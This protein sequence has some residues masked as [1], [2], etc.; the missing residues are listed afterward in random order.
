MVTADN[1]QFKK[2]MKDT[3]TETKRTG[4]SITDMG[5]VAKAALTGAVVV[6]L[7]RMGKALLNVAKQMDLMS[8][9][10]TAVFGQYKKE[11][12]DMAEDTASSMGL[13]KTEFV[14]TAAGIQ[15]LL[16]PIGFARKEATGMT[17]DMMSLAGALSTW[18]GGTVSATEVGNI[19]AKAMLGEREQLKTLGIA[20]SEAEIQSELLARGQKKLTGEALAQAKAQITLDL[21]TSKSTDAQKAFGEAQDSLV[22]N[23]AIV[24]ANVRSIGE[25]IAIIMDPAMRS[26]AQAAK[27]LTGQLKLLTDAAAEITGTDVGFFDKLRF[28]LAKAT[29]GFAGMV[30]QQGILNRHNAVTRDQ[31]VATTDAIFE[32]GGTLDD[33]AAAFE[34]Y[35]TKT[36]GTAKSIFLKREALARK[37]AAEEAAIEAERLAKIKESYD[38]QSA[39]YKKMFAEMAEA[40][41]VFNNAIRFTTSAAE[42]AELQTTKMTKVNHEA[43]VVLDQMPAT[44]AMAAQAL[45]ILGIQYDATATLASNLK[46]AFTESKIA[47]A[48]YASSISG[49]GTVL[50]NVLAGQEASMKSFFTATLQGISAIMNALLAQAIGGM[51]AG[52][53]SKGL[54]GLITGAIGVAGLLA[55]WQA[56]VPEFAKGGIVTGPTLAM[57]GDNPSGTEAIIPLERFDEFGA[58]D[59]V[60]VVGVL[61]GHDQYLM[62][63]RFS[64]KLAR[65]GR[66]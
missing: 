27:S 47:A 57:V 12:M 23:T 54:V 4:K 15:D 52:E 35:G 10:A 48:L 19:F 9:K 5:R 64:E 6:G 30:I 14:N 17:K 29:G 21:I 22:V 1:K 40:T 62:N 32:Q 3:R 11:V 55:L 46:D 20:L 49:L 59:Q 66:M 39:A 36:V 44:A 8:I 24:G 43:I 31:I 37:N 2:T 41:E 13:T 58:G 26:G 45:G 65:T 56:K 28:S 16:I 63:K 50:G 25:N 51:I 60:E 42:K 7:V 38:K 33:V 34:K 53:A 18:T 61:K